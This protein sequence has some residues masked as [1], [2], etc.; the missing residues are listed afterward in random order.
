M[1]LENSSDRIKHKQAVPEEA[2]CG[3]SCRAGCMIMR[4]ATDFDRNGTNP[5]RVEMAVDLT[6][7]FSAFKE[8][9][10]SIASDACVACGASCFIVKGELEREALV[11][12]IAMTGSDLSSMLLC[13][14]Q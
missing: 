7:D 4:L 8:V 9:G 5:Q 6:F 11:V 3:D 13:R 12:P 1:R 10:A 14:E 2:R